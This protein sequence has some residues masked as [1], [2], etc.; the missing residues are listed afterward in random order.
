MVK[1]GLG[2]THLWVQIGVEGGEEGVLVWSQVGITLK[3]DLSR[4]P[5]GRG[6]TVSFRLKPRGSGISGWVLAGTHARTP[7]R[8]KH[9]PTGSDPPVDSPAHLL[10]ECWVPDKQSQTGQLSSDGDGRDVTNR[11]SVSWDWL[12]GRGDGRATSRGATDWPGSCGAR[13]V[14]HMLNTG[15]SGPGR[16]SLL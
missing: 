12:A 4:H 10:Q 9:R 5:Q 8:R 11:C 13:S 3:G 7:S 1:L 14:L 2:E 16:G 6:G 15:S